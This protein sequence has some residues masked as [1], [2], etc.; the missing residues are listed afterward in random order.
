MLIEVIYTILLK[1]GS[2]DPIEMVLGFFQAFSCAPLSLRR[3]LE[4]FRATFGAFWTG[5]AFGI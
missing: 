2:G 4:K 1:I 3:Y 5:R